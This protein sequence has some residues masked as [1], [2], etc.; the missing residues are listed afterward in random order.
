[1]T[2][3]PYW[4]VTFDGTGLRK[5]RL[6]RGLSQDRLAFRSGVSLKTVQRVEKLPAASCRVAA[7]R[8]LAA[9]LSADPDTLIRELT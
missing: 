3:F 5:R 1:V 9:A 6:E 8:H 2:P 7:L 4:L